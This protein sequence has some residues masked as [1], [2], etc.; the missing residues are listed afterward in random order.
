MAAAHTLY[1]S[2][3]SSVSNG[4]ALPQDL[5]VIVNSIKD[6]EKCKCISCNIITSLCTVHTTTDKF[7]KIKSKQMTDDNAWGMEQQVVMGE[8]L[9]P[10]GADRRWEIE[11]AAAAQE[12]TNR[13][14][15][16]N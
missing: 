5:R 3:A 11:A 13:L 16:N 6:S 10:F 4:D 8:Y 12:R 14:E 15:S 7:I 1:A 2:Y 9:C